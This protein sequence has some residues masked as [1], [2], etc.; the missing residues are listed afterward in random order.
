MKSIPTKSIWF[1]ETNWRDRS[2]QATLILSK[3]EMIYAIKQHRSS[4]RYFYL[5]AGTEVLLLRVFEYNSKEDN[6]E[7]PRIK[8]KEKMRN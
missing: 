7:R 5:D 2:E 6:D 3:S 1:N 8:I 4:D